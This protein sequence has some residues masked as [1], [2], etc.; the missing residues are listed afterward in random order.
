MRLLSE[1]FKIVL[2]Q[3]NSSPQIDPN[4]DDYCCWRRDMNTLVAREPGYPWRAYSALLPPAMG[5]NDDIPRCVA[6]LAQYVNPRNTLL[7]PTLV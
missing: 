5:A 3:C 7:L 6:T 4:A 2:V 1:A